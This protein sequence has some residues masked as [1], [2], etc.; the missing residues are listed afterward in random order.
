MFLISAL[1]KLYNKYKIYNIKKYVINSNH[2]TLNILEKDI[3]KYDYRNK[4][5]FIFRKLHA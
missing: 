3:R 5:F 2:N 4:R 1:K